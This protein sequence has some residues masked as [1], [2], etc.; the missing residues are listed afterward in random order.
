MR[1]TSMPNRRADQG[2]GEFM[3]KQGCEEEHAR[4]QSDRPNGMGGL[5]NRDASP[6]RR[7][8]RA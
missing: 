6:G 2:M 3:G 1:R 4:R 8:P 5:T 7:W